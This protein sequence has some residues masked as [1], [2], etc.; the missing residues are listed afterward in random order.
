M[1]QIGEDCTGCAV[2]VNI[3]PKKCIHMEADNKLG[4][5]YPVVNKE[6]CV[7]C[8]LCEKVCP[9]ENAGFIPVDRVKAY[10]GE[11]SKEEVFRS[12][13]G[14]A[15]AILSR[16]LIGKGFV[17][18]GV[19]YDHDLR[20]IHDRADT[21]KAAQAFRKSKYV[22]SNT[23]HCYSRIGEDLSKGG[24]V[25]FTGVSCQCAALINYLRLRH[26]PIDNLLTASLLCSGVPS[27]KLFDL[28]RD[29]QEKMLGKKVLGFMF[30]NK[31]PFKGKVNSR[32]AYIEYNDGSSKVVGIKEDP[33]LSL[34]YHR[35]GYRP[36]CGSCRFATRQRVSDFTFADAWNYD[37]V[38]PSCDPLSGVSL[39]LVN[40]DK[41]SLY[42]EEVSEMLN[43]KSISSEWALNSQLLFRHPT[44][45]HP[46]D[47]EFYA[48]LNEL[49]FSG[50]VF[51]LTK[52]SLVKRV[53]RK[54]HAL[55][56]KITNR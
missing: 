35:L 56:R 47:S 16:F 31:R 46:R 38:D 6:A 39:I 44:T 30:K 5:I 50:A 53:K 13:S 14:G 20:V 45:L 17:V 28:Y 12:A 25:F 18:Y 55:I 1:I 42:F 7:D 37:K 15:L 51:K 33:F 19:R 41:A 9:V 11:G 49:G 34:Y 8:H 52:L 23:N 32:T 43:A 22:Q 4:H 24:K 48:L 27:Q 29:E 40:T 26:I 10:V 36:S 2:C 3:C 54:F 21:M